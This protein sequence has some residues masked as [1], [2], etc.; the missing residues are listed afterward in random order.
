M[1]PLEAYE[2][3]MRFA[4]E[5]G[6]PALRL[7]LHAA[8]PQSFRPGFLH[9]LRLNFVREA[10]PETEADVLLAP[11]CEDTGGGYY[12]FDPE[13]RHLLLDQ[14]D[15]TYPAVG[16]NVSR[17][18]RVAD[19][20]ATY[21]ESE[22]GRLSAEQDRLAEDYLS[23]QGW[24]ALAFLQPETAA[25]QLAAALDQGTQGEIAARVQFSGLASALSVPLVRYPAL[26]TYAA[27]IEAMEQ[28]RAEDA[29]SLLER[30][31]DEE[32]K[33]GNVRL[34]SPR[35][36]LTKRDGGRDQEQEQRTEKAS[37]SSA[38]PSRYG[39]CFISYPFPDRSFVDW[40]RP[41]LQ[42]RGVHVWTAPDDV[43]EGEDKHAR[44][45]E[46]IQSADAVLLVLS[47][48]FRSSGGARF[49]IEAARRAG[50]SIITLMI[51]PP[52]KVLGAG[53]PVETAIDF[54]VQE[55]YE[56]SLATLLELLEAIIGANARPAQDIPVVEVVVGEPEEMDTR[57][58]AKVLVEAAQLRAQSGNTS[59]ALRLYE[60]SV[61]LFD[62]LGDVRGRAMTMG[63]IAR[64][65]AQRGDLDGALRFHE[66]SLRVFDQLG[67]L[68]GRATTL[69]DMAG[70][71]VQRGELERALEMYQQSLQIFEQ[72]GDVRGHALTLGDIAR[73]WALRGNV[74]GALELHQK[75]LEL[76]EQSGDNRGRAIALGSIARLRSQEGDVTGA[77][78]LLEESLQIFES[79]GDVRESAMT[80]GNI[81]RLREQ[82]GDLAGALKLHEESLR[83]FERLGDQREE[84]M[85]LGSIARLRARNSDVSAALELHEKK[86]QI[87]RRIE[88]VDMV[89]GAQYDLA[90][91][92]LDLGNRGRALERLAESWDLKRQIGQ[93]EEIGFVGR[94]YGQLLAETDPSRGREILLASREAYRSI[95][96]MA[97]SG[98]VTEL[99]QQLEPPS[100]P[101]SDKSRDPEPKARPS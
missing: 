62:Q 71:F 51:E 79:L 33:I 64:L 58:R 20:L 5:R 88:D 96:R 87:G 94:L 45:K 25:M 60:E 81:A 22:R 32:I 65:R 43:E 21:I 14:L 40:L 101:M 4:A 44:I 19:F 10:S 53:A 2:N 98:E 54:S 70:L 95:G 49:E 31:P 28:G 57:E 36:L 52:E 85:T 82:S 34:R 68:R 35:K 39:S 42:A 15:P 80:S 23:I 72:I 90:R 30:L 7:A 6:E 18:Q 99:I 46:V 75:S 83:I 77:M 48:S 89:A 78:T 86:L 16:G 24:V 9:L 37:A 50:R 29:A 100:S 55:N 26:L 93:P 27:G 12:Q 84:A 1:R 17:V 13:A 66:E 63:N 69:S 74:D 76:F 11:F 91:L 41:A 47:R 73:L 61:Q 59:E 8:V 92:E 38:E 3:V 97:E 56:K 67:D